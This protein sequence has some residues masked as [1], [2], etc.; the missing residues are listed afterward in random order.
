MLHDQV[1]MLRV[2]YVRKIGLVIETLNANIKALERTEE[3]TPLIEEQINYYIKLDEE[4][5]HWERRKREA[6]SPYKYILISQREFD[7]LNAN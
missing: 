4:K 7:R 1:E 5:S 6:K 2:D 3:F